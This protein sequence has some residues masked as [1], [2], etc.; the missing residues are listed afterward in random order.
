MHNW[1]L[2]HI[3]HHTALPRSLDTINTA[4]ANAALDAQGP[5][6]YEKQGMNNLPAFA[7]NQNAFF[8]V[9]I[10]LISNLLK[11]MK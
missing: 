1:I 4:L 9:W 2:L 5:L 10:I 3:I 7:G 6:I 11:I 8:E